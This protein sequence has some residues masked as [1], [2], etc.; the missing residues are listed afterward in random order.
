MPGGELAHA[1]DACSSSSRPIWP[2]RLRN[3][4]W[5]PELSEAKLAAVQRADEKPAEVS[6][7]RD[8][9]VQE[10]QRDTQP[11]I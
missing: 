11:V 10:A 3:D 7:P 5:R 6:K 9:R 4:P 8:E 1:S 2:S